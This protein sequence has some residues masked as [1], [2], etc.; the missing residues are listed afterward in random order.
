MILVSEK[1]S[2]SGSV[3]IPGSKSHTI[4]ALAV[5]T[6]AGGTSRIVAPLDS[7]DTRACLSVCRALGAE[8]AEEENAWTVAGTGG[9]PKSAENVIDV[10]NSGTTLF[11]A[12]GMGAL[13][14]RF[15]TVDVNTQEPGP[16]RT[17]VGVVTTIRMQ[18]PFNI[19]NVDDSG[20]YVPFYAS[21]TGPVQPA[22]S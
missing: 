15:R 13:G 10:A 19:P 3:D 12:L 14:R 8:I 22:N 4:R 16:W 18:G 1:A 6:L 20:F 5:A 9:K 7:A 21:P 17:I 11:V 2:L